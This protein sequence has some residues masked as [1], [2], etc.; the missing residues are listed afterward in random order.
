M[1]LSACWAVFQFSNGPDQEPGLLVLKAA[2]P[3]ILVLLAVGGSA[4]IWSGQDCR[5]TFA[6]DC[7]ECIWR[8]LCLGQLGLASE[9]PIKRIDTAT[10]SGI[11]FQ[12]TFGCL[13]RFR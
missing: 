8:S 9:R 4:W 10:M 13:L 3:P 6:E 7:C 11:I 1:I 5:A 2:F 12:A